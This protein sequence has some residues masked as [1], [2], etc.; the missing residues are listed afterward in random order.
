MQQQWVVPYIRLSIGEVLQLTTV[1]EILNLVPQSGA[2]SGQVSP[3]LVE[4]TKL[5][6]IH[7]VPS[8]TTGGFS[9]WLQQA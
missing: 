8:R 9:Y 1:N 3:I 6:L 4:C 5:G 2:L 7:L